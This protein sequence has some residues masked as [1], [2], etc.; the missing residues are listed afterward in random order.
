MT[1]TTSLT[2]TMPVRALRAVFWDMDGTLIDSEPYWHESELRLVRQYGGHWT[3]ELAR[4]GSGRPVPQIAR[5]MVELGCPLP[6]EEIDRRMIEY[7]TQQELAHMPWIPGT[8]ELLVALR[9]AGVP[10][11]LVTTSPRFLA[12]N[13][14]AQAP[15]GVFAGYV[16]GDDDVA[17]KPDPAPYL[18]AGKILGIPAD[19][20]DQCVAFEDSISGRKSAA[21]AG[22]IT[23]SMAGYAPNGI[24]P[25]PERATIMRYDGITPSLL[26]ELVVTMDTAVITE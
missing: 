12:E 15:E 1:H 7:V 16:C 19:Q 2:E 8:R 26:N 13:L 18:R 11:V 10:S 22:A 6:A 20:M 5:E 23:I 14:I 25:G 3:Q 9:D 24:Q 21:A 4:A 17:K